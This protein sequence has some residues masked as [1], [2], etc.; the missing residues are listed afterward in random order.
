MTGRRGKRR[1]QQLYD[2]KEKIRY[3]KLKDEALDCTLWRTDFGKGYGIVVRQMRPTALYILLQ[4]KAY[5]H[6]GD[7][8]DGLSCVIRISWFVQPKA[9]ALTGKTLL[10]L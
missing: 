7:C 3:W 6:R 4:I 2:I 5:S 10:G 8:R 9:T 1:K